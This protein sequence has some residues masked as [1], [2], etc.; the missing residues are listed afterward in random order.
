MVEI[1]PE[2]P[3]DYAAVYRVNSLAFEREDEAQ[4]VEKLRA[5]SG[6]H[7][8][9]V[10]I[11]DKAVVG[12]IF[13]S[14]VTISP[15]ISDLAAVGLAP[16]AVLPEFQNQKIGSALVEAGLRECAARG[17]EA[18]FVLGHA[19]YY[20]RFGFVVAKTKGF[21]CEYEVP[22]EAFMVAE[23]NP[24]ALEKHSGTVKYRPEFAEV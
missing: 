16:M 7:I 12:H 13:F 15:Q 3:D 20:P 17:Y 10:A 1:R 8:S 19:D 23:L 5:H 22:D 18:V 9:L 24:G 4:L 21:K 11:K 6:A 2:Q 14:P